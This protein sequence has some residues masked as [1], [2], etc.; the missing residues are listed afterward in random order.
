MLNK[1]CCFPLCQRVSYVS[2][3]I[4]GSPVGRDRRQTSFLPW[5][6]VA[7]CTGTPSALLG[8]D[9]AIACLFSSSE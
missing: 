7:R 5:L 1:L 4:T 8:V 2:Q 3:C 6:R 9:V